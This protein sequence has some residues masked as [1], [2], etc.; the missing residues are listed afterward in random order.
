MKINKC[1]T[2]NKQNKGQNQTIIS[3]V[4]KAFDKI[5]HAFMIKVCRNQE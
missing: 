1:N 4:E 5:Q 2:A 3:K